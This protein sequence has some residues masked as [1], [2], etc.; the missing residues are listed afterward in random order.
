MEA[1]GITFI[2]VGRV[3]GNPTFDMNVAST[4]SGTQV[5]LSCYKQVITK[6]NHTYNIYILLYKY[7]II[8]NIIV[9][10]IIIINIIIYSIIYYY[11]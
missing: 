4:S 7:Y 11:I 1:Q 10:V 3:M 5:H 2:C 6:K 8:I 9:Y